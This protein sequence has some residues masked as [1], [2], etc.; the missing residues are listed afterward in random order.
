V[1]VA[2]SRL[3]LDSIFFTSSTGKDANDIQIEGDN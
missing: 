2:I 3:S 1:R